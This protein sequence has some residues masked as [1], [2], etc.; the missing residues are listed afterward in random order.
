ML[1]IS[2]AWLSLQ[3]VFSIMQIANTCILGIYIIMV[4]MPIHTLSC[5]LPSL[6]DFYIYPSPFFFLFSFYSFFAFGFALYL[7][8]SYGVR[9]TQIQDLKF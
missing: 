5:I 3:L 9:K 8:A 7:A 1:P 2:L 4:M 6:E